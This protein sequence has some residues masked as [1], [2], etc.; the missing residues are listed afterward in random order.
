MNHQTSIDLDNA[1]LDAFR[2]SMKDDEFITTRQLID[3]NPSIQAT[4]YKAHQ[5]GVY[6]K[7]EKEEDFVDYRI[8]QLVKSENIRIPDGLFRL[9]PSNRPFTITQEWVGP[10][11]VN[12]W[13]QKKKLRAWV[14]KEMDVTQALQKRK[15]EA[16][17]H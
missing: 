14:K 15:K 11:V 8:R 12:G 2:W 10:F 3:K 7:S 1:I 5:P 13:R 9:L 6:Y 17:M 4:L 16:M